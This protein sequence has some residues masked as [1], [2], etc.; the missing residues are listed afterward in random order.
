MKKPIRQF[1][2]KQSDMVDEIGR[3]VLVPKCKICGAQI[4]DIPQHLQW[5]NV[6]NS[7]LQGLLQ[8]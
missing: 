6:L 8:Q 4:A 7:V 3:G 5:H 2:F 1:P